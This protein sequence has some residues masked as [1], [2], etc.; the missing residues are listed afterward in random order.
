MRIN[1]VKMQAAGN[2]FVIVEK[3]TKDF[4]LRG[5][6]IRK[7]ADRHYGVGC[8]QLL[9][10]E[11]TEN[12]NA[13]FRFR[14]FNQDG[15]EEEQCGKGARC[16]GRFSLD[17]GFT[18]KTKISLETINRLVTVNLLDEGLV[19]VDM[20]PPE[21]NPDKVPFK[22]EYK[23]DFYNLVAENSR[24]EIGAINMGNTHAIVRVEDVKNAD[25]STIGPII[26]KHPD[27]PLKTNVEFLQIASRN[28]VLLRVYE[29]GAGETLACGSGACAA[30]VY[31]KIRGWLD[32]TVT[33]EFPGGKLNV[34]WKGAG[35][36]VILS[37][38]TELV[39]TGTVNI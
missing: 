7:L 12:Q 2:D 33:V 30:V 1:F 19:D 21:L 26:E 14:I 8:D 36:P 5:D 28:K 37:G 16:I 20:G 27:F 9:L 17:Q 29:R 11:A 13:D 23:S 24:I 10:L 25:V 6:Q 31:G 34:S 32:E 39:F 35:N 3:L 22:A 38:L 18:L 15:Q 4:P